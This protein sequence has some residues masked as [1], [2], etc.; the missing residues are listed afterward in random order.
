MPSL[1]F[2]YGRRPVLECLRAHRR[3]LQRVLLSEGLRRDDL[4]EKIENEAIHRHIPFQVVSRSFFDVRL[5]G[6]H[7]Q[8]V[9]VEAGPYPYLDPRA[10]GAQVERRGASVFLL[11]LDHLQDPQNLGAIL[12][13]AEGAGVDAVVIP[14]RRAVGVTPAVVRASAGA[15]EHLAVVRVANLVHAMRCAK[16]FGVRLSGLVLDSTSPRYDEADLSGP[17][18]LVIGNENE[19][20]SRLAAETC[21]FRIRIPMAGKIESL[22]AGAAAAVALYEVRR[23]RAAAG[24]K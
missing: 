18:G 21:D 5:N 15:S 14:E 11:F 1:E 3:P 10:F 6:L 23:Q 19:G 13:S 22:N 7:H 24:R 4:I 16:E 2:L 12:R 17:V 20:L 9:A 8:G